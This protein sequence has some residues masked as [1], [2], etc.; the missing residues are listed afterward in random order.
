MKAV[1][2]GGEFLPKSWQRSS[3]SA[4]L[5]KLLSFACLNMSLKHKSFF[6]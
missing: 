2:V 4:S 3:C 5:F 1:V 6:K